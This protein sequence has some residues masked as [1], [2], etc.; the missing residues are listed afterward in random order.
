MP[1]P[2]PGSRESRTIGGR[3]LYRLGWLAREEQ[4]HLQSDECRTRANR[5]QSSRVNHDGRLS[6]LKLTRR[7][8]R[9]L[10]GER[11]KE[12]VSVGYGPWR[13]G[14][15]PRDSASAQRGA[16]EKLARSPCPRRSLVGA[17]ENLSAQNHTCEKNFVTS[18]AVEDRAMCERHHSVRR[19]QRIAHE[20]HDSPM[21][22]IRWHRL[23][24]NV[25]FEQ[26][27]VVSQFIVTIAQ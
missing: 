3:W 26:L 1:S 9:T 24:A 7:S 23:H 15:H 19:V 12:V 20:G 18:S 27:V 4:E 14:E 25:C 10:G 16:R 22:C 17:Q 21:Q 5:T 13:G 8:R 6:T 2:V 11:A